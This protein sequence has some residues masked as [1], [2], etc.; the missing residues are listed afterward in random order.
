MMIDRSRI[1]LNRILFPAA[2]LEEFFRLTSE[3]GLNKVELRNDIHGKGII[4]S[5]SPKQVKRLSEK[6]GITIR[7]I[8]ALQK[9]NLGRILPKVLVELRELISLSVAIDCGAIVLVPNNEVD[10]ERDSKTM[11]Q[12]TIAALKAF[13]PLFEESGLFG[14]VE[15]LGFEECSLRSK[16]TAMKA[17]QESGCSNYKI[18][19]D[20]FHHH[21][22]PDAR[23][24]LEN[25]YDITYTGLVHVSGVEQ[26]IPVNQ[27]RDSHRFLITAGDNLKN[28]EQ[29]EHLIT[30]GYTGDISFEPFASEVQRM[31]AEVLKSHVDQSI[32]FLTHT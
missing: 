32:R 18:V 6:Y 15:P 5:Y 8:N 29:I 22:G 10:D 7:T 24:A 23:D 16:I 2:N 3:L 31:E 12:E 13:G 11:M 26:D 17:I 1:S 20:T 30:L 19:H 9:F 21:L 14:Y 4:D 25:E 27:Y 28:R